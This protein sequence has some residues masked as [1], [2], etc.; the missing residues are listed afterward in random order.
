MDPGPARYGVDKNS[1]LKNKNGILEVSRALDRARND[2]GT[3]RSLFLLILTTIIEKVGN[4]QV[5]RIFSG[6]LPPRS[7]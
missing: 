2:Q 1:G 6:I 4:K 5:V 7:C 3:S